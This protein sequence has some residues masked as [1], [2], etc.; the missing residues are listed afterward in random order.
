MVPT[1]SSES[2]TSV[3]VSSKRSSAKD[4]LAWVND[5]HALRSRV[6]V[7]LGQDGGLCTSEDVV[8]VVQTYLELAVKHRDLVRAKM[9]IEA[10]NNALTGS[11][12]VARQALQDLEM[13]AAAVGTKHGLVVFSSGNAPSFFESLDRKLQDGKDFETAFHRRKQMHEQDNAAHATAVDTLRREAAVAMDALRR[14]LDT[15][16]TSKRQDAERSG[17]LALA[18]AERARAL[19]VEDVKTASARQFDDL[20]RSTA[21]QLESLQRDLTNVRAIKLKEQADYDATMDAIRRVL[22]VQATETYSRRDGGEKAAFFARY[23]DRDRML[24]ELV[25]GAIRSV[26][27][28]LS[29]SSANKAGATMP[30]ELSHAILGCIKELKRMKEYVMGSFDALQKDMAPFLPFEVTW[31]AVEWQP[32]M[33]LATWC[34]E[35]C[36]KTNEHARMQFQQF[37][38]HANSTMTMLAATQRERAM[39]VLAFMRRGVAPCDTSSQDKDA[40][41]LKMR[42]MDAVT[43]RDQVGLELQLKETFFTDLLHQH[44]AVAADM[45][46]KLS[47]QQQLWKAMMASSSPTLSQPPR[48]PTMK[49]LDDQ[50]K[51]TMVKPGPKPKWQEDDPTTTVLSNGRTLKERFV[52]DLALETGQNPPMKRGQTVQVLRPPNANAGDSSTRKISQPY[53]SMA[54]TPSKHIQSSSMHQSSAAA[55][56]LKPGNDTNRQQHLWY[57]GVKQIDGQSLSLALGYIPTRNSLVLDVFNTDTEYMQAIEVNPKLL[58][59]FNKPLVPLGVL[60]EVGVTASIDHVFHAADVET[61]AALSGD[62]NPVH[63]DAA[64]AA[65]TTFGK[66]VVHGILCTSLFPTIFGAT[67]PGAI[68]V[69]QDVRYHKPIHVG[70]LVHAEI[71]VLQVKARMRL[72]VCATRCLDRHGDVAISGQA[73]VLLPKPTLSADT[74][75]PT[76]TSV[77]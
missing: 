62:S 22:E 31:H 52:S 9:A 38:A 18:A 41:M 40:S 46:A 21:C 69:A 57:Q 37:L 65:T 61:F 25:Y 39:E 13:R 55:V 24:M 33:D 54:A 12:D 4:I 50:Q 49:P 5:Y 16:S 15:V 47:Q 1:S 27:Q 42:L 20:Q 34:V 44:K 72:V 67:F 29:T 8:A 2:G 10:N 14:D 28:L 56:H 60:P 53:V 35:S 58:Q 17:A 32:D 75:T 11:L 74:G 19:E 63:V 73:K 70:D 26:T 76:T 3:P 6:S 45:H 59:G 30:T 48:S 66:P 71:E 23:V 36:N 68:Y 64:F 43:D 51:L 7:L 77:V